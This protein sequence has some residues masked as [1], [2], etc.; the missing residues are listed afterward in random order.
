[1]VSGEAY[2]PGLGKGWGRPGFLTTSVSCAALSL[3]ASLGLGFP[4]CRMELSLMNTL[5]FA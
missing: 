5:V 2:S 3:I 1:M 4:F